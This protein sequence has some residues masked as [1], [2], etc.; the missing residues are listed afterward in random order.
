MVVHRSSDP[1]ER[2]LPAEVRAFTG[3]SGLVCVDPLVRPLTGQPIPGDTEI[4]KV[5]QELA[6]ETCRV[7][8]ELGATSR[9][10]AGLAGVSHDVSWVFWSKVIPL[11][12]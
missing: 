7:S 6:T 3:C 10:T 2:S 1:L 12:E 8:P 5:P 9:S 4:S 11:R